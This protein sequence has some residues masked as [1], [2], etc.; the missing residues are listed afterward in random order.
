VPAH[1]VCVLLDIN[2]LERCG[3]L[4]EPLRAAPSAKVVIDHHP[5]EGEPWWDAAYVDVSA[6][7]TGLLVRRIARALDVRLDEVAAWAVFTSLVTDTGWF[8]YSNTDAETLSLAAELIE[9]GVR[10]AELFGML[11]QQNALAE[12]RALGAQLERLEYFAGGRLALIAQPARAPAPRD[13]DALLDIVRSVG[14]VE[15][16][17]Y[18]KELEDGLCKLSARSKTGYDV[19]ALARRFGGGGHKKAAGATI[20]GPLNEVKR[21]LV[22]AALE[23]FE[24]NGGAG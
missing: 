6:A 3:A 20:P 21:L 14:D 18:L 9:L 16:V 15:V 19:N 7:A 2:T 17:L 22:E 5:F 4:E 1:D 8:R 10:P 24:G 11:Y 12:P 13:T 23:G